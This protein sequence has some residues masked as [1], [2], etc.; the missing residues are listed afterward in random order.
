[1]ETIVVVVFLVS[2]ATLFRFE[3]IKIDA[4]YIYG[5]FISLG[6]YQINKRVIYNNIRTFE[7]C[8]ALSQFLENVWKSL[9]CES[10]S[11]NRFRKVVKRSF[12]YF[13]LFRHYQMALLQDTL[14]FMASTY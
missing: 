12:I 4:N 2:L 5:H 1:L 13:S 7:M 8:N 10:R 14:H 9:Y 6:S 11:E 3:L